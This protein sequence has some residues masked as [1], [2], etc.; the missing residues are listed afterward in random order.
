MLTRMVI[1]HLF[2]VF[3][4]FLLTSILVISKVKFMNGECSILNC[5]MV[6]LG[7]SSDIY[8]CFIAY[9]GSCG[10]MFHKNSWTIRA[11]LYSCVCVCITCTY[12]GEASYF[13]WQCDRAMTADKLV[14]RNK[15]GK[16]T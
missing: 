14:T 2:F 10:E 12:A 6:S 3:D 9:V 1:P 15:G 16:D 5:C 11:E 4:S 13:L 8:S 7:K